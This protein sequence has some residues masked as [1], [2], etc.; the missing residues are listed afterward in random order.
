MKIKRRN[1]SSKEIK[2]IKRI[3]IKCDLFGAMAKFNLSLKNHLG[4]S[5]S[6]P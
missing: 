6:H 2:M 1:I 4:Q 5:I 3:H